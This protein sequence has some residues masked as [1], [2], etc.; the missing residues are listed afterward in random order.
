[1]NPIKLVNSLIEDLEI[2]ENS[3]VLKIK[4][5]NAF[6]EKNRIKFEQVVV[7]TGFPFLKLKG[8]YF[9]KMHQSKSHVVEVFDNFKTK[10]NRF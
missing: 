6:T 4:G 2:Y 9:M 1:M 3:Q 7:C 10:G 5:N 8:L